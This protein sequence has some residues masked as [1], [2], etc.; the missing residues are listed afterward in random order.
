MAAISSI[1]MP[2]VKKAQLEDDYSGLEKARLTTKIHDFDKVN[3]VTQESKSI[4]IICIDRSDE[5]PTFS[6]LNRS[7]IERWNEHELNKFLFITKKSGELVMEA[8]MDDPRVELQ[9]YSRKYSAVF[10]LVFKRGWFKWYD[11]IKGEE[12]YVI[13]VHY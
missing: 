11:S 13:H 9:L 2:V 7:L 8:V 12:V 1:I 5:S 3:S 6:A 4:P 10:F